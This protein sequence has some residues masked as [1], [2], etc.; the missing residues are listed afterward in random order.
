MPKETPP[1]DVATEIGA[2]FPP[3]AIAVVG[4][5]ANPDTP[6]YDYVHALQTFG[7]SGEIYPVNPRA[8]EILGLPSY[9]SLREGPEA[10][11]GGRGVGGGVGGARPRHRR[12]HHRPELH[13]APLPRAG[14]LLP[15]RHAAAAGEDRLPIAER[16]PAVRANV[17]RPAA[18]PALL[19]G[20]QDRKS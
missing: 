2:L 6:G 5:S 14:H 19:Q 18:R 12:P 3:R 4:A 7:Y 16:E 17:L 10:G 8:E 15:R 9:P 13:G 1:T 20:R 11:G